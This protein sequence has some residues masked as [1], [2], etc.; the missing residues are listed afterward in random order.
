MTKKKNFMGQPIDIS[1]LGKRMLIGGIIAL[2]LIALFIFP[3][4]AKPEWGSLWTVRPFIVT[5]LAGATG[6]AC[7]Y[8]LVSWSNQNR[9]SKVLAYV[10]SFIIFIFGLWIGS[11]LGLNGTLWN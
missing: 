3:V 1:L 9:L 4:T 2:I 8:F 7:N 10:L 11:I 5:T 6:G